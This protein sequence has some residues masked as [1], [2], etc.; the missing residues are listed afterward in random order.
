[1]PSKQEY[2]DT[3]T[4]QKSIQLT[5]PDTL[6]TATAYLHHYSLITNNTK[7]YPM[8]GLKLYKQ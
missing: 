1:L 7:D 8:P 3:P 2:S 5:A 4:K 6:I